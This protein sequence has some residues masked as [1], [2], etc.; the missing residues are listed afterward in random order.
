MGPGAPFSL[1][2][3]TNEV[4]AVVTDLTQ[5]PPQ[6]PDLAGSFNPIRAGFAK[7]GV[8]VLDAFGERRPVPVRVDNLYLS[9]GL[10]TRTPARERNIV[11]SSPACARARGCCSAGCRPTPWS[12]TR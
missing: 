6:S 5:I 2:T 11:S 4:K 9:S 7:V 8:T 12:T 3:L 1:R 10:T